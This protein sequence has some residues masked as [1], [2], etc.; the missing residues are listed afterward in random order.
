MKKIK[1]LFA[2]FTLVMLF[3]GVSVAQNT[4]DNSFTG[5]AKGILHSCIQQAHQAG[6]VV[7][8]SVTMIILLALM[9]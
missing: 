5:K 3:T 9:Q 2:A 6:Y 1:L 8:S 7:N 4:N